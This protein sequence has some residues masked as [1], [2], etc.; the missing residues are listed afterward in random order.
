MDDNLVLVYRAG[1]FVEILNT[2]KRVVILIVD[3]FDYLPRL[4]E[5]GQF[6]LSI[7]QRTLRKGAIIFTSNRNTT[8]CT[9]VLR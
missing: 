2:Y 8:E 4:K 6:I 1:K 3:E 7:C 9:E 5:R